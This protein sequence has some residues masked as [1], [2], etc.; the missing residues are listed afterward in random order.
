MNTLEFT[1]DEISDKE[2]IAKYISCNCIK[3]GDPYFFGKL[4]GTRYSVQYYIANGLYNIEFNKKVSNEFYRIISKEIGH[5]NFQIAGREW[6]SIPLLSFLPMY[7][8][9]KYNININSFMIKKE[10][11]TYGTHNFIEGIPNNLPVLLVDDLCNSTNSFK[12]C[13]D[14]IKNEGLNVLPF[15]FAIL[16]KYYKNTSENAMSEDRYLK[17]KIKPLTILTGD[18]VYNVNR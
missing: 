16:N 5:F 11:K 13:Y 14:I 18:D 2:Y 8:N 12:F 15:I 4:P 3:K 6:S 9:L 17:N 10:R 1:V 7:M